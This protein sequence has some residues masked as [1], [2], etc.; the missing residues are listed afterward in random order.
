MDDQQLLRYSRH[1]LLPNIDVEGQ[2]KLLAS[3]AL[4]IGLGG[5]GSPVSLYLAAAGV[6]RLVLADFD[7]VDDSNLQRQIVHDESRIGLN[8]AVSAR[9]QLLKI[10]SSVRVDVVTEK[11]TPESLQYWVAQSQVVLDCSDNFATR[12]AVNAACVKRS[13]PLVSGAA[14]RME[15]QLLVVDSRQ[16]GSPCYQCLYQQDMPDEQLRCADAG[17]LAPLVGVM[18]SLQAVEAVKVLVGLPSPLGV[19]TLYDAVATQF[20]SIKFKADPHCAVCGMG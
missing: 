6:G 9:Q 11:L 2:E 13:V 20:R 3:T 16:P 15:G 1:I 12:F 5:L 17:V 7:M 14:I 4:I 19:L 10:N 8:K 18:G